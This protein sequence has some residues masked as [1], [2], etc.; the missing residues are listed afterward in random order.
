MWSANVC[1]CPHIDLL[2]RGQE[3][4]KM[5]IQQL[6]RIGSRQLTLVTKKPGLVYFSSFIHP[7]LSVPH[8]GKRLVI[9]DVLRSTAWGSAPLLNNEDRNP[10]IVANGLKQR[11]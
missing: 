9:I 1:Y 3:V 4:L 10:L 8:V 2:T 5:V 6:D 11:E 7:Y